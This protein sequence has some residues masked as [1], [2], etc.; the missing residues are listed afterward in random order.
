MYIVF[1]GIAG[2]GKTTQIKLLRDHLKNTYPD[3]GCVVTKEPGGDEIADKIRELAQNRLYEKSLNPIC[4][5]YLYASSR[6]QTLRKIVKYNLDI[7]NFVLSDRSFISSL[8]YQAVGRGLTFELIMDINKVAIS[9]VL[10]DLIF[11]YDVKVKEG[12]QRARAE[13]D[14]RSQEDKW[15]SYD[16]SFY[17]KVKNG[18]ERALN[19]DFLKDKVY[20]IDANESVDKI[21]ASTIRIFEKFIKTR[22]RL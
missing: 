6:A 22:G 1:E 2:S 3:K 21:S 10:P 9:E 16:L 18:Y 20:I 17:K 12:L 7:G 14:H 4:E 15:E 19:M 11:Y 13:G 8:A 5:A